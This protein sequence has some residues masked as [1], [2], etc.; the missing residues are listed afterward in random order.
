MYNQLFFF[1]TL[2]RQPQ[3]TRTDT[4]FPY[5]TLFRSRTT[6]QPLHDCARPSPR[7]CVPD[8]PRPGTR[9]RG[10]PADAGRRHQPPHVVDLGDRAALLAG[11]R[12]HPLALL[13][14]GPGPR[15]RLR[16]SEEHTYD[17]HS[18]MSNTYAVL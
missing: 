10:A 3:S 16:K 13:R 17:L 7:R 18:L 14:D 11:A 8:R 9:R 2:P 6:C 5:T 12:G 15:L 1:L 4:P